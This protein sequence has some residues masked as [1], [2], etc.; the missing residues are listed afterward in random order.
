MTDPVSDANNDD[1]QQELELAQL[2]AQLDT[3]QQRLDQLAHD[4]PIGVTWFGHDD[5]WI[6]KRTQP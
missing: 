2:D 6:D 5:T 3:K 4:D 1:E